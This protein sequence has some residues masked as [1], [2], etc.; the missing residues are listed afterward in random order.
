[1]KLRLLGNAIRL[2]LTRSEVQAAGTGETVV[3]TTSFPGGEVFEF[4]LSPTASAIGVT[5]SFDGRRL[6]VAAPPDWLTDWAASDRVALADADEGDGPRILVEKDF[7]CLSPRP[8]DDDA[9]TFAHPREGID[10]C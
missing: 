6:T 5:A 3:E 4:S 8:G 7:A 2:R 10:T 1:M 9:D